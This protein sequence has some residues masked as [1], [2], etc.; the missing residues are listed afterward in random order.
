MK[1][2]WNIKG[3]YDRFVVENEDKTRIKALKMRE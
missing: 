3:K 1:G 2:Q